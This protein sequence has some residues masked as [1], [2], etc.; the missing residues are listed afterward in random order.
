MNTIF[1]IL[2]V[3]V[4]AFILF[5]Q[6]RVFAA[7]KRLT[8]RPAPEGARHDPRGV[9]YY[10]HHPRCGPCR[11]MGPVIDEVA[12]AHPEQVVKVNLAEDPA[13]AQ[14][15]GVLATPTTLLVKDGRIT[16]V[17]IGARSA[18]RIAALLD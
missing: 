13:L 17:I 10:F 5:M 16:E 14:A 2:V 9:V 18:R 3:A 4:V 15:F 11:Q 6:W 1:L 7:G 12:A 8:G